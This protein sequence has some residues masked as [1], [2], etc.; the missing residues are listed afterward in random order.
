M[1]LLV[2]LILCLIWGSTWIAIKLG[3]ADAPPMAALSF[4]FLLS[5]GILGLIVAVKRLPLPRGWVGFRPHLLPGLLMY[6][7][8]YFCVYFAEQYLTSALMAVLFASFPVFVAVLS[9]F[10][11]KE[12][13]KGLIWLGLAAGFSGVVV[14]SYDSL[15][16]STQLLTGAVLATLSPLVSA[17][18]MIEHTRSCS[19]EHP[20]MSA[21]VQMG[22]GGGAIVILALLLEDWSAMRWTPQAVG[23]IL[24]LALFGSVAGFVGYYWLLQRIRPVTAALIAFITPVIALLIGTLA[25]D[26]RLTLFSWVGAGLILAGVLTVAYH[27]ARAR[28]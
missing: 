14:I 19:R 11:L 16:G 2:Y 17:I 18:G 23:S 20:V 21:F 13:Q 9:S 27:K 4:R 15:G 25:F 1:V 8:S 26:E 7:G 10:R 28:A 6:T 5:V 12:Q 22:F 3:L 24:Y